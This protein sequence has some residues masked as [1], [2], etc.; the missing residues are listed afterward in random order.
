MSGKLFATGG[1][2]RVSAGGTTRE[3]AGRIAI[4]LAANARPTVRRLLWKMP[5]KAAPPQ[6]NP[7]PHAS[8]L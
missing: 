6:R 5:S 4:H 3:I 8:R 7:N 2:L 1:V